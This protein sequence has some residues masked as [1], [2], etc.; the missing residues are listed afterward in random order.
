MTAR[1]PSTIAVAQ[2]WGVDHLPTPFESKVVE[3]I[4]EIWFCPT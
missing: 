4:G 3:R 2:P 1:E